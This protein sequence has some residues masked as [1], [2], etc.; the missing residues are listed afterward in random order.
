MVCGMSSALVQVTV[1]PGF[2]VTTGALKVKLPIWTDAAAGAG[3]AFV[4]VETVDSINAPA[5]SAAAWNVRIL[6][7]GIIENSF[8]RK[9]LNRSAQCGRDRA[10]TKR[11]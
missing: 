1:V 3:A 6:N 5:A 7:P 4:I 8:R 11:R 10:R 9:G 2:T